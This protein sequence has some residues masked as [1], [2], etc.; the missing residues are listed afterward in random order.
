MIQPMRKPISHIVRSALVSAS[1]PKFK[2][3]MFGVVCFDTLTCK[4]IYDGRDHGIKAET[5]SRGSD[6]NE[7]DALMVGTYGDVPNF[8]GDVQLEWTSIDKRDHFL[9]INLEEVFRESDKR[10]QYY[11]RNRNERHIVIP[12]AINLEWS[13]AGCGRQLLIP[14]ERL[15]SKLSLIDMGRPEIEENGSR[16]SITVDSDGFHFRLACKSQSSRYQDAVKIIVDAVEYGSTMENDGGELHISKA[17]ITF[18][19]DA[20][21][22]EPQVLSVVP[23]NY[24]RPE[25]FLG[26]KM[27]GENK[28]ILHASIPV[29]KGCWRENWPDA[30]SDEDVCE[31][32]SIGFTHVLI[33]V[34]G[35]TVAV[36]ARTMIPVKYPQ[37]KGND[38]SNFRDD[39]VQVWKA[40]CLPMNVLEIDSDPANKATRKIVEGQERNPSLHEEPFSKVAIEE[41]SELEKLAAQQKN[42][43]KT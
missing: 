11:V 34:N 26:I 31:G 7:Y 35:N 1:P 8:P 9:K 13:E 38:H 28:Y 36:Y 18:A 20:A 17:K 12:A 5:S 4:A 43:G 15:D 19:K 16:L 14:G 27:Y 40:I 10:Y 32:S 33:E 30:F 21:P 42:S 29:E 39:L 24:G 23:T 2:R 3:H 25:E 37:I 6:E 41:L 22:Q